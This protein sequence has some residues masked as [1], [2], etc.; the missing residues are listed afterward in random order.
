M[1]TETAEPLE[2]MDTDSQ[3]PGFMNIMRKEIVG[4]R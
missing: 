3:V 4:E 1:T 2:A